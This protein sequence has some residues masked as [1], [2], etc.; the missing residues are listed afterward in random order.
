M[1]L[2]PW[3]VVM[4]TAR[5]EQCFVAADLDFSLQDRIRESLPALANRRPGAYSWPQEVHA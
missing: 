1:I 2:D 3:G 4:A 5:D